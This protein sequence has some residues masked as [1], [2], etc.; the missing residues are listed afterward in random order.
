MKTYR[1]VNAFYFG[2]MTAP[3]RRKCSFFFADNV[4]FSMVPIIR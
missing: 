3:I 1:Y 2:Q 4:F